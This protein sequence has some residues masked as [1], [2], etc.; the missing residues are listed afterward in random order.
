[1]EGPQLLIPNSAASGIA[2]PAL[3]RT[4]NAKLLALLYQFEQS[5]WWP[6]EKLEQLQLGQ[7]SALLSHACHHVPFYRERLSGLKDRGFRLAS[8]A[9]LRQ[10]PIL[11]REQV[12]ENLLSLTATTLPDDHL[13]LKE[14]RTSGSTGMPVTYRSTRITELLAVSLGLRS[15]I[16]HRQHGGLRKA[17]LQISRQDP[18]EPQ[19]EERIA[20]TSAASLAVFPGGSTAH[21]DSRKNIREQLE[22]LQQVD[23]ELLVTFPSNLAA[24]TREASERGIQ[25]PNLKHLCTQG[26]VVSADMREMCRAVWGLK[27]V[28]IYS[29]RELNTIALQCPEQEHYH[30][31]SERVIVEVLDERG[32][33]CGPGETGRV[34]LT[35]PHNFVMPFVR[36]ANGDFAEVGEACTCG[37]QMPVL[38]RILG[39]TRNMLVLPEGGSIWPAYG[40]NDLAQVAPIRQLQAVQHTPTDIELRVVPLRPLDSD[41]QARLLAAAQARFDE[42]GPSFTLRLSCVEEIPRAKSGKFEDFLSLVSESGV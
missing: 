14:G 25:L 32:E 21:F 16:W 40:S 17:S 24:L 30:V 6:A 18:R 13:P 12:Q 3:P 2:W 20:P 29:C 37:R 28:D 23:P 31:Q 22:W 27:I 15:K 34:V 39:R 41:A 38:K 9:D 19:E 4:R 33:H 26:E 1:L 8:Y 5:Q 35:D 7:L 36:Y 42:I 10:I 11:T